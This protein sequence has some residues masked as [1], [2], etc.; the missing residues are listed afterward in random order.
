MKKQLVAVAAGAVAV[1][2][3]AIIT[4][5]QAASQGPLDVSGQPYGRAVALLRSQGFKA[6]FGGSVGSDVPQNQCIVSSQKTLPNL[7]IQLMLN[8]T[9]AAQPEPEPGAPRVGSNGITTVTATPVAPAPGGG[10]PGAAAPAAPAP[11]GAPTG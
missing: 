2:S 8:C 6:V 10:A 3:M 4:T 9:E 7:R 1:A 5:G 11:G